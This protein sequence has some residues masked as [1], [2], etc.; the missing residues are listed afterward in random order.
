[1]AGNGF[2]GSSPHVRGA[3]YRRSSVCLPHGIIPA[4]A[5]S[6]CRVGFQPLPIGDHPRMCGEHR[7]DIDGMTE[8]AGSSP[9]V[10]GAPLSRLEAPRTAG[11]IPA[12]AGSTGWQC[13]PGDGAPGSS[14]H[15]RGAQTPRCFESREPGIIPACAGSTAR[16]KSPVQP[17]RDHP[18]MCGEH[19]PRFFAWAVT[20]G[21]S[22]HVRGALSQET[23]W[24]GSLGIIPACAGSTKKR[25][26]GLWP[27]WDHP[28]MCGEHW[29]FRFCLDGEPGSS[30]HVRGALYVNG[31]LMP[32]LGIIPACAGSTD[33]GFHYSTLPGDHP[34]MCGEHFNAV[35]SA[36]SPQGSSPHVRGAPHHI[37]HGATQLGIIPACAGSTWLCGT[38]PD[39]DRDHPRMCGEHV[40]WSRPATSA[41]GSSPHVRGARRGFQQSTD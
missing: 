9:H 23:A 5:G 36:T 15:V 39:A 24:L 41:E 21:S 18:R 25:H 28:R 12:C 20:V 11:I 6:T 35:R 30:P 1:M 2:E 19:R 31:S 7:S 13:R 3:P 29:V 32:I 10:R 16:A 22:P 37:N 34:R 27:S 8:A 40:L 14:P 38:C 33:N 4:C 17:R 26:T